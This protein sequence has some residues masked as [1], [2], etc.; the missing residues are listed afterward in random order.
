MSLQQHPD[1]ENFSEINHPLLK[2]KLSIL[3]N[4]NTDN[5]QFRELVKEIT[6]LMVYE[7]TN[8]LP[9]TSEH[10]STPLEDF[11][12]PT[13]R[14]KHPV[15]V[16]ILR[17][18]IGMVDGFLSLLPMAKVGH[19]GLYRDEDTLEPVWY[20]FKI[21]TD[22]MQRTFYICDP[23]LATGG[24]AIATVDKL[25]QAGVKDIIFVCLVA[26]PEGVTKLCNTHPDVHVY[27]A[28]LDRGLDAK[29]Y[30]LPGLGDAGDRLFGTH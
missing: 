16:P 23:M 25:K 7:V 20:Y 10:I 26:S 29:S 28:H 30:I 14:D 6:M 13:L 15:I 21:P 19:V 2:H 27:A 12:A 5:K 22:S 17:A 9:L 18:G 1:V 4:K 24:S 3:R 11:D 8:D